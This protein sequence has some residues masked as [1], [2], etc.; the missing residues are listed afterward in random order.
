MK[1]SSSSV[2]DDGVVRG[3]VSRGKVC[4]LS[5]L[6][7]LVGTES[8]CLS[9]KKGLAGPEIDCQCAGKILRTKRTMRTTGGRGPKAIGNA[10]EN[11]RGMRGKGPVG[12]GM[13]ALSALSA[14]TGIPILWL[15]RLSPLFHE[16][17]Q[18]F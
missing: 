15:W 8:D 13:C 14:L 7:E 16:G 12:G 9:A 4:V 6:K 3:R 17:V 18:T 10:P 2:L 1:F 11:A 5:A